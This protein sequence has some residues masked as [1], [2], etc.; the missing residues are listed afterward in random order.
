MKMS[1]ILHTSFIALPI[2]LFFSF[3]GNDL[4]PNPIRIKLQLIA[5][6]LVSPLGMTVANDGSNRLFILEQAGKIKI[7]KNG[8]LLEKPFL[9]I[10][11]KLDHLNIAYSE[12][13][14]LGMAFHPQYKTN[15]KFF[16]YY[17]APNADQNYDHLSIIAE[18]KV[19]ANADVADE[20]S[21]HIIMTVN[22][23]ES[24][25]NGGC[26]M[27][28][29]DGK[30]YIGLGD[31]GGAGD[32]HGK[33]GNGQNLNTLLGK[34]LRIDVDKGTPYSIPPDNP[35]LHGDVK[36]EIWAYGLRNPWRFSFDKSTGKLYCGDVGQNK[37]EEVDIIEKGKNYGW[38]IME[39]YHCFNPQSDCDMSNLTFPI[40]EYTHKEGNCVIGGYV[41]RGKTSPSM[42]GY[43]FFGDWTGALFALKQNEKHDWVR[44]SVLEKEA[45]KNDI[46]AKINSFGEDEKGEIYIITQHLFGPH[47]PTGGVYKITF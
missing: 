36:P 37:Y 4:S 3:T 2:M 27:F 47:S 6:G 11:K 1:K 18:Y 46:G 30:L 13:G 32:E 15:G 28:G 42:N 10:S 34:M 43:Y 14:L 7:I 16:I 41:Y 35:F 17:S 22:E 38:R 33:I 45:T 39:G 12:K 26:L 5:K 29:P 40:S 9:D 31:G 44:Y 24:N 20:K 8:I 25:H 21:E 23:P 19:S